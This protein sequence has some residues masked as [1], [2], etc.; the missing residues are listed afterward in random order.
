MEPETPEMSVSIEI[1][2]ELYADV[3]RAAEERH[4]MPDDFVKEALLGAMN[5]A[6]ATIP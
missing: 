1:P 4:M 3:T 6:S 2:V 5:N